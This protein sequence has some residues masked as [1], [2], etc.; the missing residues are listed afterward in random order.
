[1]TDEIALP[2]PG[3]Y[4]GDFGGFIEEI[5]RLL[6]EAHGDDAG[7]F[8]TVQERVESEGPFLAARAWLRERWG[9]YY[10]CPVCK[11]VE[12]TVSSIGPAVRPS[13]FLSFTVTCGYCGNSMQV[14]P[15]YAEMT[16]PHVAPSEQPRFPVGDR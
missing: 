11:N 10:E 3:D 14:V 2:S 4:P 1:M 15:G 7:L 12:W 8:T 5:K 13:G 16:K 6:L 9:E